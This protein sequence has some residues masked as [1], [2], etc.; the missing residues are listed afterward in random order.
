[1]PLAERE[2]AFL[3]CGLAVALAEHQQGRRQEALRWFERNRAACGPPGLFTRAASAG[4]SRR[5]SSTP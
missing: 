2:G 5:R 3:L 4:T 1:M